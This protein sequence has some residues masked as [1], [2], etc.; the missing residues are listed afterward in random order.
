M[1][2]YKEKNTNVKINIYI[3]KISLICNN[4]DR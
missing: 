3:I 2:I 1:D 4:C